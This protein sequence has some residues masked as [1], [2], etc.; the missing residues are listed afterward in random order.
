MKMPVGSAVIHVKEITEVDGKPVYNI[1]TR[2]RSNRLIRLLYNVDD[3]I[4]SQ[5]EVAGFRPL[6]YE[7]RLREGRKKKDEL[8]TFDWETKQATYYKGKGKNQKKRRDIPITEGTQDP[9]SSLF[10]LRGLPLELGRECVMTVTT[11]RKCWDVIIK[12]IKKTKMNL[13]NIGKFDVLVIEPIVEFE[14]L[15]VH[16]SKLKIWLDEETK[17]P[18][19]MVADI[20][21][22]SITLILSKVY[23][24]EVEEEESKPTVKTPTPWETSGK[25]R[26]PAKDDPE[27][28]QR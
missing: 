14:G 9:L 28:R 16:E 20:P 2:T 26:E 8:I 13:R 7:K 18:L 10:F 23:D 21:I 22:G 4:S 12:P 27:R 19:K 6:R 3:K 25:E 24:T 17:I 11:E 5:V 1:I 15:F